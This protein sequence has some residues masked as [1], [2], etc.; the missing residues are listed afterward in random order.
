M[1]T[2][3]TIAGSEGRLE[4]EIETGRDEVGYS[5]V[6]RTG[7][8]H[9]RAPPGSRRVAVY[10]PYLD[11]PAGHYRF[12]LKFHIQ[13]RSDGA[14]TI[15]L[16]DMSARHKHYVRPCFDWELDAGCIRLSFSF[17]QGVEGLEVRLVVPGDCA[18]S[19]ERLEVSHR[20]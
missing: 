8:L 9:F 15:E 5:E 1:A 7:A 10:G 2:L 13:Q 18:G 19:I 12:E 11:L 14:F 17:E 4:S 20:A 6:G 16:C 3:F